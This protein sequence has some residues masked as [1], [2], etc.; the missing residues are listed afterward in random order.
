MRPGPAVKV[1]RETGRA[2]RP[3]P[4]SHL[5]DAARRLL[6]H[7]GVGAAQGKRP[8]KNVVTTVGELV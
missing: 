2:S 8:T 5:M 3:V 6:A 1:G 4:R 7:V